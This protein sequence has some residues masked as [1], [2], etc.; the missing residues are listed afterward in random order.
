MS[1]PQQEA[2][3]YS[4]GVCFLVG[5]TWENHR[6]LP[7]SPLRKAVVE[8][9][10]IGS[11]CCGDGRSPRANWA[12][13]GHSHPDLVTDI[14]WHSGQCKDT[15]QWIPPWGLNLR[16]RC[17]CLAAPSGTFHEWGL[18]YLRLEHYSLRGPRP[19]VSLL[20]HTR[21]SSQTTGSGRLLRP[22]LSS[23]LTLYEAFGIRTPAQE[24]IMCV[25]VSIIK[26]RIVD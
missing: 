21:S 14:D 7:A 18:L 19:Q 1:A 11:V 3:S 2:I 10:L 4:S 25:A 26:K 5:G 17:S 8:D 13:C 23:V 16:N 12:S 6:R 15:G 9:C 24:C 20:L 22:F